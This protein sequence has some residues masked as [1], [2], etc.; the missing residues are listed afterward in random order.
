MKR[1]KNFLINA[2]LFVAAC[3]LC[4]VGLEMGLRWFFPQ[5]IDMLEWNQPHPKASFVLSPNRNAMVRAYDFTFRFTT[6]SLGLRGRE[7]RIREDAVRILGVGDSMTFGWGVD[8]EETFLARLEKRIRARGHRVDVFNAGIPGYSPANVLARLPE[9]APEMR[10]HLA[11]LGFFSENDVLDV[12]RD[13]IYIIK[14]GH[15]EFSPD[16]RI[17][18]SMQ[19]RPWML[20]KE[21]LKSRCHTYVFLRNRLIDELLWARAWL[22]RMRPGIAKKQNPQDPAVGSNN[23]YARPATPYM[24]EGWIL[25]RHIVR[26]M[27]A[28]LAEQDA[29]LMVV[30]L[31]SLG[32]VRKLECVLDERGSYT[33][34]VCYPMERM[35]SICEEEGIAFL[36]LLPAFREAAAREK[37][38]FFPRDHHFDEEGHRLAAKHLLNYLLAHEI[39]QLGSDGDA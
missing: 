28:Y 19:T 17:A 24:E 5:M 1:I 22:F 12:L 16:R 20:F 10:P 8:D 33:I 6:N 37:E 4:F 21:Y 31:P 26:G 3:V 27:K 14:D 13:K 25:T 29:E 15:L 7:P 9:I 23:P 32:Q 11:V 2:A 35:E 36:N 18:T 34:D 38:L 30:G 39:W